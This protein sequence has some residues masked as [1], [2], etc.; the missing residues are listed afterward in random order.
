MANFHRAAAIVIGDE[1]LSVKVRDTNGP[2]LID[3]FRARGIHLDRILV[4]RDDVEEI[5]WAVGAC[6]G[7]YAPIVTSGGIGPT[8]DD[9]TVEG[10]AR[11]MGKAVVIHPE[12][13]A[14]VRAHYGASMPPEALRLARVPEGATLLQTSETW[15]PVIRVE[16]IYLLPGIPKLFELHVAAIADRYQGAPFHLR[17]VYLSAGE[18]AIAS[19]LDRIARDH[20]AVA[21]GSYPRMGD[22]PYRVKLTL[23]ARAAE[24]VE[25]ALAD[26]LGRLDPGVVLEV[27]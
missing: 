25:K 6:R 26:L 7:R 15:F 1:I 20:P 10:V 2:F 11:G 24:P 27:E 18:T 3:R 8:H 12:L 9:L 14:R 17:C 16:E 5:A 21:L 4:V 23:E 13:E 22:A 19:V